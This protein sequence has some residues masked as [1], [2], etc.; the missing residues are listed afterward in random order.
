MADFLGV[1]KGYLKWVFITKEKHTNRCAFSFWRN[2]GDRFEDQNAD[3]GGQLPATA[4]QSRQVPEDS[5]LGRVTNMA[6][7]AMIA[8]GG[9]A[10]GCD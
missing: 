4:R 7:S 1:E 2:R 3:V 10:Y 5:T 6:F 9:N 8:A